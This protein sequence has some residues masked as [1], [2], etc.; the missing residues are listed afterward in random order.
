MQTLA[1]GTVEVTAV[2]QPCVV[3]KRKTHETES[4]PVHLLLSKLAHAA[5]ITGYE[6]LMAVQGAE[7]H[8]HTAMCLGPPGALL[9]EQGPDLEGSGKHSQTKEKPQGNLQP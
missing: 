1:K 4:V 6:C 9:Q 2:W 8:T 3:E 5:F 7:D